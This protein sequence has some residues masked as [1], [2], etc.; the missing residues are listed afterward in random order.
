[1]ITTAWHPF[2]LETIAATPDL[3]DSLRRIL[4]CEESGNWYAAGD[5]YLRLRISLGNPNDPVL[6]A[7]LSA[8]AGACFETCGQLR[9]AAEAFMNAANTLQQNELRPHTT[10]ELFNKA[11]IA[12]SATDQFFTA[13]TM[14]RNSATQFSKLNTPIIECSGGTFPLP[15]GALKEHMVGSCYD[16][17]AISA[18]KTDGEQMWAVGAYWEAGRT[19]QTGRPNIQTFNA[20]RNALKACI[21]SY[22]TLDVEKLR[23]ILPLTERERAGKLNPMKV[24]E[25]A[26][27]WCNEHHQIVKG[28]SKSSQLQTW[29][30]LTATYHSFAVLFSSIGN[31]REASI[32][33]TLEHDL[34]RRSYML[35]KRY[36]GAFGYLLWKITSDY[37]ESVGRWSFSCL[38]VLLLFSLLFFASKSITP[39]GNAFDYFYFSTITFTTL[40]YGDIHPANVLGEA[41]A[42]AEVACGFIMFGMLLTFLSNRLLRM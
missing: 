1:M 11:A 39:I 14:W 13:S 9:L 26:L 18:T 16:A 36:A 42:C 31:P 4:Q 30:E 3:A 17:A 40:G 12:F 6:S 20:Y 23:K 38:A 15:M 41:L 5:A 7:K 10:A 35:E 28:P 33:R 19:Y 29:K 27:A 37:G 24:M 25:D 8:R 22:G 21:Q 34:V 2:A 32:F